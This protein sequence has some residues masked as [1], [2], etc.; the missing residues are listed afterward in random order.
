VVTTLM[1]QTHTTPATGLSFALREGF[2]IAPDLAE[3][4]T[5][6]PFAGSSAATAV[7]AAEVAVAGARS[8][9]LPGTPSRGAPV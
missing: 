6:V 3:Q 5:A 1:C 8:T 9:D 7:A 4:G 2:G